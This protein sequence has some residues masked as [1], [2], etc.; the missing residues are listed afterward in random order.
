MWDLK[1]YVLKVP[2]LKTQKYIF[3]NQPNLQPSLYLIPIKEYLTSLTLQ[4][5]KLSKSLLYRLSALQPN[6]LQPFPI[7]MLHK[8]F[9]DH[10]CGLLKLKNIL[11]IW[12]PRLWYAD[13]GAN[14][15]F[16]KISLLLLRVHLLFRA[17]FE[18]IS[19]F[20]KSYA[21]HRFPTPF[22][23]TIRR[24]TLYR[25][26]ILLGCLGSKRPT[27]E[28]LMELLIDGHTEM[29]THVFRHFRLMKR[30]EK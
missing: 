6:Y 3:S 8:N 17:E 27:E 12:H 10:N 11:C 9:L 19:T 16:L 26:I 2:G 5:Q 14:K 13:N 30:S 7:S 4:C 29:R 23:L 1:I 18:K 28:R 21:L 22:H 24:Q 20:L 25:Y 15:N